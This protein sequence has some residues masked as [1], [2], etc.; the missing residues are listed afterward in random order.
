MV[1]IYQVHKLGMIQFSS[2]EVKTLESFLS[3]SK[4]FNHFKKVV[5]CGGLELRGL[6]MASDFKRAS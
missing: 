6:F 5:A 3:M 4:D 1:Y 2:D